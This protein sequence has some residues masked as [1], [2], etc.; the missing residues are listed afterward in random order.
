MMAAASAAAALGTGRSP[1]NPPIRTWPR[2]RHL[3]GRCNRQDASTRWNQPRTS[4][5]TRDQPIPARIRPVP[6]RSSRSSRPRRRPGRPPYS[7][8]GRQELARRALPFTDASSAPSKWKLG[9]RCG[10]IAWIFVR[11][12]YRVL[13]AGTTGGEEVDIAHPKCGFFDA[14][15]WAGGGGRQ[16]TAPGA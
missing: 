3:T 9:F 15:R 12:R 5:R 4:F 8:V 7:A 14:R 13:Q 16:C 10:P 6:A 1:C 2:R 11:T